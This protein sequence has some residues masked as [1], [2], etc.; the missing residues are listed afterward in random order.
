MPAS[1][2]NDALIWTKDAQTTPLQLNVPQQLF[3]K[4]SYSLGA[5]TPDVENL[6]DLLKSTLQAQ[7][8]A[9]PKDADVP[10]TAELEFI[11]VTAP[12]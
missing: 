9:G 12:Y 11:L 5:S 8:P 3:S 1:T 4:S 6:T 2:L 7:F 10:Y